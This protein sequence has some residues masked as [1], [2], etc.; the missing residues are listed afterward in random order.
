MEAAD[1][2]VGTDGAQGRQNILH[3]PIHRIV[4]HADGLI[5]FLKANGLE[6]GAAHSQQ[7][8]VVKNGIHTVYSF[9]KETSKLAVGS[10]QNALDRLVPQIG[11]EIDYIHGE[12]VVDDLS[13]KEGS[14]GFIL[15]NMAKEDLFPTVIA[16]GA[17][18]RKTFS[19]GHAHDKRFYLECRRITKK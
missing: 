16:D 10:L 14:I 15:P 5:D 9:A 3:E 11:G 19:M 13:R 7:I 18:P 17:L 2:H 1:H 12:E 8:E 4:F 6:K